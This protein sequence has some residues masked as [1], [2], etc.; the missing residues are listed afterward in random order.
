MTQPITQPS[1]LVGGFAAAHTATELR[2]SGYGCPVVPI[3]DEEHVP[4]ER[5]P[6]SK[7]YLLGHDELATAFVHPAEW[8]DDID[9]RLS[10]RFTAIHARWNKLRTLG[11]CAVIVLGAGLVDSLVI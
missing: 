5:P 1:V 3:T 8:Y 2:A 10:C 7:G 11:I 6:L 4:Y 9:L